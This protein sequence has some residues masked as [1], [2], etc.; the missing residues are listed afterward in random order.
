MRR[1]NSRI[2]IVCRP[3]YV[4]NQ[5]QI[6]LYHTLQSN[7]DDLYIKE[8][9]FINLYLNISYIPPDELSTLQSDPRSKLE[10]LSLHA[11]K[12]I[13]ESLLNQHELFANMYTLKQ[14]FQRLR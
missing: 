4:L 13:V 14:F 8:R 12:F 6:V 11:N 2:T 5:N 7:N 10:A 1:W 3:R 9:N